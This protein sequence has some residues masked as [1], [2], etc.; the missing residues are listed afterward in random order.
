[1]NKKNLIISVSFFFITTL[2]FFVYLAFSQKDQ[3]S[4]YVEYSVK[5]DKNFIDDNFYFLN[6]VT[7]L[8]IA[9]Y[10][11][12][13][14]SYIYCSSKSECKKT[15]EEINNTI[16]QINKSLWNVTEDFMGENIVNDYYKFNLRLKFLKKLK[17]PV[18]ILLDYEIIENSV[19]KLFTNLFKVGILTFI[20]SLILFMALSFFSSAK[21]NKK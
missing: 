1:M 6:I 8:P 18:L 17:K 9:D 15:I 7:Q 3:K 4:F 14:Y 19:N 20:L 13:I 2:I 5:Y 21:R 12:G 11:R 10:N 16:I